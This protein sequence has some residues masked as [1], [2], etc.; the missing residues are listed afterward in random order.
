MPRKDRHEV[1]KYHRV[2]LKFTKV[3]ACALPKCRHHM[4]EYL[5]PMLLGKASICWN[6]DAEFILDDENMK[7]SRPCCM[8][9]KPVKFDAIL[10]KFG[11]K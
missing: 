4:P 8:S 2:D 3:W 7:D 10:A 11:I 5:T 1:H 6:C 9:C